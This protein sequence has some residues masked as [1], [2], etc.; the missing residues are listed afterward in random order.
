MRVF[1]RLARDGKG[2]HVHNIKLLYL[3]NKVKRQKQNNCGKLH[4]EYIIHGKIL[5]G[6]DLF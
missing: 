3:P 2:F 4:Q 5:F 6:G 1:M